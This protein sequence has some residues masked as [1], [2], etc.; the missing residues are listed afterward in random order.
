MGKADNFCCQGRRDV[1]H[2]LGFITKGGCI[3]QEHVKFDGTTWRNQP[4]LLKGDIISKCTFL[5]ELVIFVGYNYS[6]CVV[7][8]ST[9]DPNCE[10]MVRAINTQLFPTKEAATGHHPIGIKVPEWKISSKNK[11]NRSL[12]EVPP[13]V[14]TISITRIVNMVSSCVKHKHLLYLYAFVVDVYYNNFMKQKRREGEQVSL[15]DQFKI[16]HFSKKKNKKVNEKV[17]DIWD[18]E[19]VERKSTKKARKPSSFSSKHDFRYGL[20]GRNESESPSGADTLRELIF[21]HPSLYCR[22]A[23]TSSCTPVE[24][25]LKKLHRIPG[26]IKGRSSFTIQSLATKNMRTELELEKERSKA[27]EQEI[28]RIKEEQVQS[29]QKHNLGH[30]DFMRRRSYVMLKMEDSRYK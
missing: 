5:L 6:N 4:D 29:Q 10:L 14:G 8:N 7:E 16:D 2:S 27:L 12:N 25:C 22:E 18:L 28:R 23:T 1:T 15:I 3:V 11:K 9:F 24:I 13:A 17:D 19:A 30:E 20:R 21:N 26:H